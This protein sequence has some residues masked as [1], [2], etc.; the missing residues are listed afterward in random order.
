VSPLLVD[1]NTGTPLTPDNVAFVAGPGASDAM[2]LR[3]IEAE[4]RGDASRREAI[5]ET[6]GR[7]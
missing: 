7:R 6:E 2:T 1:S 4:R 5:A 3:L